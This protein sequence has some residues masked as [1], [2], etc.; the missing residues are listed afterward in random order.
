MAQRDLS[1]QYRE[2]AKDAARENEAQAWSEGLV[3]VKGKAGKAMADQ[4]MAADKQRLKRRIGKVTAA[5]MLGIE[6]ALR[7][8]LGLR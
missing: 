3:T 8:Q 1:A 4:V 7:V 5:E 2:A 6:R